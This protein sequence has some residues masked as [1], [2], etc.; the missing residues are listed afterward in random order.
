MEWFK[1]WFDSPYYHLL[2]KDRDDTEAHKFIDQLAQFLAPE[3]TAKFL[4]LACGKGRHSVYLNQKGYDVVGA[5]LAVQ[6]IEYAKQFENDRL[7]FVRHDMRTPLDQQFDYVLN[8]FTSFGYFDDVSDNLTTIK[9]ISEELKPGGTFVLDFLN[10]HHVINELVPDEEKQVE[11]ILFHIKRYHKDH[12]IVKE[13][14]F[15]HKGKD[16]LFEENVTA[17]TR[18]ELIEMLESSGLHVFHEFGDYNLTP[19]HQPSSP[20]LILIAEKA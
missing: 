12:T 3:T 16:Y 20:R 5:D 4:D 15:T 18:S 7:K 10:V 8:M 11:D 1:S 19:F 2:Y 6:N 17:F 13:I 14:S 9:A